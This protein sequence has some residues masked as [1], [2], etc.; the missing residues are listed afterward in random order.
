MRAVTANSASL[1]TIQS[2]KVRKTP[3]PSVSETTSSIRSFPPI[4][5][6][7]PFRSSHPWST[8]QK[9]SKWSSR[10]IS[11][12]RSVWAGRRQL[13]VTRDADRSGIMTTSS[14]EESVLQYTVEELGRK[15][16]EAKGVGEGG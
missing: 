7:R 10:M 15:S 4:S 14:I 8:H 5:F 2:S 3:Q 9:A 6:N 13:R 1:H 16:R 12:A 11:S